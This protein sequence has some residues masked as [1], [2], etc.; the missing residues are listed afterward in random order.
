MVLFPESA[1]GMDSSHHD[2]LS[3]ADF[4]VL[5]LTSVHCFRSDEVGNEMKVSSGLEQYFSSI[6][7]CQNRRPIF[8]CILN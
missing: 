5:K 2:I 6:A 8:E 1:T 7:V 3:T 4:K